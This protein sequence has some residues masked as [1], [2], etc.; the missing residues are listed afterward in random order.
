[1]A[2]VAAAATALSSPSLLSC[3]HAGSSTCRPSASVA[4]GQRTPLHRSGSGR[5]VTGLRI[6]NSAWS[7]SR[8]RLTAGV[9]FAS[10][11]SGSSA[12]PPRPS[13]NL[14]ADGSM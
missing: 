10:A 11:A 13:E 4:L 3:V 9:A 14:S 6:A 1:M 7:H 2:A 8:R 12:L 5:R